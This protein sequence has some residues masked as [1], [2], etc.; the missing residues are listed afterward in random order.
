METTTQNVVQSTT[1]YDQFNLLGANRDINASMVKRLKKSFEEKG[2][3]M[4][5]SPILVNERYEVIDG[6]HRLTA[7]RELG[8]PVYFTI[9]PGIGINEARQMNLL[10][11]RWDSEAFLKTY[12]AEGRR[13]YIEF[14]KLKFDY[15]D[16]SFSILI[17]AIVGHQTTGQQAAF[18]NGNLE[19]FDIT[20]VRALLDDISQLAELTPIFKQRSVVYAYL[21]ARQAD[22]FNNEYFV[23]KVQEKRLELGAFQGVVD[24]LRQFEQLYN[25]NRGT[26]SR[27]RFY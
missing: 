18:R 9:V 16:F 10:H 8:V 20:V 23:D 12:S 25:Q 13:P 11:H 19:M 3:L 5:V 2:N 14:S 21:R 6:Q 15:P 17:A 1:N 4:Q 22:N 26:T 7:A 27:V 24:N